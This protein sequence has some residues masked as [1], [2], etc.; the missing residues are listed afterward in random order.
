MCP[1]WKDF[2]DKRKIIEDILLINQFFGTGISQT[3]Y[4]A[5]LCESSALVVVVGKGKSR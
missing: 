3:S 5:D 2:V 1:T 4:K